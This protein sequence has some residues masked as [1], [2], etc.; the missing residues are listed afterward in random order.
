MKIEFPVGSVMRSS[1]WKGTLHLRMKMPLNGDL[2]SNFE[3]QQL[4]VSETGEREWRSIQKVEYG[5]S[6]EA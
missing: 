4:W 1:T 2:L 6:D 3:L 5:A